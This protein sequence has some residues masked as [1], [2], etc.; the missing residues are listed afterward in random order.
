MKKITFLLTFLMVCVASF[1]QDEPN[2]TINKL[3]SPLTKKGTIV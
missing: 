1:A 3:I 2:D